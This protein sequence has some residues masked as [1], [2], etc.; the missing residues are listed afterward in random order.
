MGTIKT[1]VADGNEIFRHGLSSILCDANFTVCSEV[2]NGALILTAFE[3]V[4]PDLCVLSFEMPE[5]NGIQ[6][7]NKMI[8]RFPEAKILMLTDSDADEVLNQFLDSG[9][10]GLL[11][12]SAHRIELIDAATKVA[13][14]ENFLGKQFSH[15]MTREY[16]R[17]A[18]M[19][20]SKKH[21]T[22]RERE[23]LGLLVDGLT[24][25][26]IADKL[27]ISPRTVDKH[28]TN[29]LKKLGLKNT[30]ALVRYALENKHLV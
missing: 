20:K 21:V 8:A 13:G 29:L 26:E 22:V 18:K 6:L 16:M 5:I 9:A 24:S 30:P 4:K 2:D 15:M 23:V 3:S 10:Q 27:F 17:L 14:G 19:R 7:A 11:L 1:I 28:R 12:K 25:T